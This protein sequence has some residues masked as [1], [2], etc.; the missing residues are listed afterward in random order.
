MHGDPVK[1]ALAQELQRRYPRDPEA[2]D[3]VAQVVRTGQPALYAAITDAQV[4]ARARDADHLRLLRA[5]GSRSAMIV[6][7]VARGHT[8]GVVSFLSTDPRRSYGPGDL[9]L[10][11]A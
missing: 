7:L 11:Q 10:A 8:L 9:R 2:T 6:P 5:L 4:V 3:G 1:E